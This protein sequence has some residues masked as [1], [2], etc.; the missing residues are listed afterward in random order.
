M[1]EKTY[2]E[3]A[4]AYE[5]EED[6]FNAVMTIVNDLYNR[7]VDLEKWHKGVEEGDINYHEYRLQGVEERLRRLEREKLT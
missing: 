1:N 6:K 7:I 5:L 3:Q 2:S 4:E